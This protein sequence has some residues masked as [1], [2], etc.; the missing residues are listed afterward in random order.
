MS[1]STSYVSRSTVPRLIAFRSQPCVLLLLTGFSEMVF[2][3][4]TSYFMANTVKLTDS[5]YNYSQYTTHTA[6][7]RL[8]LVLL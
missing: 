4:L 7:Y 5:C 1:V 6:G 3:L 8:V 2:F